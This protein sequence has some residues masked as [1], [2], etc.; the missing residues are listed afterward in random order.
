MTANSR[1]LPDLLPGVGDVLAVPV[2]GAGLE[3][4]L[5]VE[6]GALGQVAPAEH[7]HARRVHRELCAHPVAQLAVRQPA[8]RAGSCKEGG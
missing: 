1:T 6:A 4:P 2:T 5:E 8:P 7:V 3:H